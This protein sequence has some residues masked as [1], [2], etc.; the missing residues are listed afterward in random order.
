MTRPTPIAQPVIQADNQEIK[1]Y[2]ETLALQAQS[3][4]QQASSVVGRQARIVSNFN[5]QPHGGRSRKP[6]T[7][8]VIEISS[9]SLYEDGTY[10]FCSWKP[11]W[12][13][14]GFG[15]DDIEF[16]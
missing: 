7:G 14:A 13:N 8:K 1:D 15:P 9:V 5:G 11:D 2:L 12:I 6:L 4:Q 16:L 10:S 3:L